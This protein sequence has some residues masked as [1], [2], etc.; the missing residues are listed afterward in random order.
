MNSLKHLKHKRVKTF[1]SYSTLLGKF[2]GLSEKNLV[3][4]VFGTTAATKR[5]LEF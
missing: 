4:F 1:S 2:F 5:I 3:E